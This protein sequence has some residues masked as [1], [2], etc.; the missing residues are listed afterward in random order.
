LPRTLDTILNQTFTN[1]ELLICDDASPDGTAAVCEA[2]AARDARIRY[3]RNQQNLGMPGNLNAG[4]QRVRCELVANLHDGDIYHPELLEKW[5]NALLEYPSAGFV[6]N[7]YRHLD[8]QGKPSLVVNRFPPLMRGRDFLDYC[9]RDPHLENPVWGTVMARRSIYQELGYFDPQYSFW[10]DFDMWF[11]IAEKYDVAF[12]DEALIDL[13]SKEIMPHLFQL[14]AIEAHRQM[15]RAF[16]AARRRHFRGQRGR[17]A[18]EFARQSSRFALS[19]SGRL[20]GR[21]KRRL[22]VLKRPSVRG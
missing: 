17:L 13:P 9:F 21:V 2:Y 3:F 5:R 14:R 12:V 22:N 1:F 10:A 18:Y 8:A 19:R 7:K 20:A 16:W 4:L 11:R 15:F 6:F